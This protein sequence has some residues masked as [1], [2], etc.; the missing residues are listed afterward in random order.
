M[1]LF[2]TAFYRYV[3]D[4]LNDFNLDLDV[5]LPSYSLTDLRLGINHPKGWSVALFADNVFDEAIIYSI[6]RQ[7]AFFESVPTNRPRTVGL[8]FIYNYR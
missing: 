5:K 3:G 2:A 6:D 8:N 7:G 1:G 4:R